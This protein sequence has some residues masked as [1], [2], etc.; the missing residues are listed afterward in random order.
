VERRGVRIRREGR[1]LTERGCLGGQG[2]IGHSHLLMLMG[3][4]CNTSR[5]LLL[6]VAA[7]DLP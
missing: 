4:S 5:V 6:T 2:V 7:K 3:K 1:E